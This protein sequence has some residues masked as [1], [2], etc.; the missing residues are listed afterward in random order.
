MLGGCELTILVFIVLLFSPLPVGCA[1][2]ALLVPKHLPGRFQRRDTQLAHNLPSRQ[3]H[4]GGE[5][6]V[7]QLE[8]CQLLYA[9]VG[10]HAGGCDL[11]DFNSLLTHYVRTQYDSRISGYDQLAEALSV[12]VYHGS[13]QVGV[14]YNRYY[15]IMSLPRLALGKA[16]AGVF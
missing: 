10:R 15:T 4:D 11:H 14:W 1:P 9:H 16:H 12:A 3:A 2:V 13:I 5:C 8:L 7:G 6:R